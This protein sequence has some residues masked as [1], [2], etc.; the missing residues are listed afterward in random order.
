MPNQFITHEKIHSGLSGLSNDDKWQDMLNFRSFQGRTKPVPKRL[1]LINDNP[2]SYHTIIGG[3]DGHNLV[4]GTQKSFGFVGAENLQTYPLWRL[5]QKFLGDSSERGEQSQRLLVQGEYTG[6]QPCKI[7][8]TFIKG[9]PVLEV[10]PEAVEEPEV[11]YGCGTSGSAINITGIV[12]D[13]L[14]E[15]P[16]EDATVNFL[17]FGFSQFEAITPSSGLFAFNETPEGTYDIEAVAD[18][19]VDYASALVV[20]GTDD[21]TIRMYPIAM[22]WDEGYISRESGYA[23]EYPMSTYIYHAFISDGFVSTTNL[24]TGGDGPNEDPYIWATNNV[25]SYGYFAVSS[26]FS[27]HFPGQI[28]AFGTSLYGC[29]LEHLETQADTG[30]IYEP[31]IGASW[32][33]AWVSLGTVPAAGTLPVLGSY[34]FCDKTYHVDDLHIYEGVLYICTEEHKPFIL[35]SGTP[36]LIL[37]T[38]LA[39]YWAVYE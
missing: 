2:Q 7:R 31:G 34:D 24:F 17:R 8:V 33:D 19:Y 35:T 25:V 3:L 11:D 14:T 1:A 13:F 30:G 10:I 20:T 36:T 26:G 27:K 15:D 32:S 5:S 4:I 12:I 21:I 29:I 6:T 16:I 9:R 28:R 37:P 22:I 23:F 39:P 18:G 38:D